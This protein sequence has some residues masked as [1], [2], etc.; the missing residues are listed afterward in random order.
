MPPGGFVVKRKI[1]DVVEHAVLD[2]SPLLVRR[3]EPL[4]RPGPLERFLKVDAEWMSVNAEATD[5]AEKRITVGRGKRMTKA[6]EHR[7]DEPVYFG[8]PVTTDVSLLFKDRY[9]RR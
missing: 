2:G 3:V 7:V 5:F 4:F 6:V 1:C 8:Y 9:A